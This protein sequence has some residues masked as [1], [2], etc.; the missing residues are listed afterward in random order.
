MLHSDPLSRFST[1]EVTDAEDNRDQIVLKPDHFKVIAATAFT[2]TLPLEK[3]IRECTERETEVLQALS[4]LKAKGPRR[5]ANGLTEWEEDNG[6]L[7]YK[8]E[9]Y[10]PN[11]KELRNEI[12]KFCHD[13]LTAGY[14]GKY[15]T[16]ELVSRFY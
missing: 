8:G 13:T 7:Y 15:V 10:I 14:P 11:R 5:L 1:H 12:I 16:M 6:L 3:R 2:E 4:V 9:L